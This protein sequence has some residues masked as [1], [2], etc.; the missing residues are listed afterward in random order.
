MKIK[1]LFLAA[2]AFSVMPMSAQETYENVKL[3]HQDLNGTARYVGMGG[4]MDALGADLSTISSNPAGLGLFRRSQAAISFG[5]VSQQDGKDFA[6]G[7]KTNASFDQVGFVYATKNEGKSFLNF[8]FNYHK[9][10]N[11]DF[12]LST[13]GSL[14]DASQNKLTYIKARGGYLFDNNGD[15]YVSSSRLDELYAH[16]LL[17]E[18]DNVYRYK[19]ATA[20]NM[21]RANTGYIGNYEFSMSG[22][23]N[24][25]VYLGMTF[26]V[27]DVHY[28]GYSEY[29]EQLAANAMNLSSI[30]VADNR[31]ITGD[32]YEVKFGAIFRPIEN[33]PFRIGVSIASPIFYDLTS[34]SRTS[35]N[36][37]YVDGSYDFKISTPWKFGL[38][39]GHTVGDF[40][41]LG[42]VYE[43]E[44][45]GSI[46]SRVNDGEGWDYYD[47]YYQTSSSDKDMNDQTEQVLKGVS[48]LK[49][50]LEFKPIKDFAIRVGYNYQ[51]AIYDKNGAKG[52]YSNGD[53]VQSPGMYYSSTMDY[54]NW[55]DTNRFTFGLGYQIDRFSVDLAYQYS[56]T[57]GDFHP[58]AD[59]YG[60]FK[61]TDGTTEKVDNYATVTSVSNKR[62]QLLFTLGYRF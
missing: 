59:A 37:A 47:G 8:G 1:Y 7:N 39:L 43:Y 28:K 25:R 45:Y 58:F 20:F 19:S 48:T 5:L 54:T 29:S 21:D 53:F 57:N 3:A 42:A 60:D 40:L 17:L 15:D 26:G 38:S 56:A 24:E 33:S 55:K 10:Q 31:K 30:T 12:I 34:E 46:D 49:L 52:F 14:N 22:N 6:N 11:F 41:A 32:G 16:S 35:L 23:F 9:S 18:S 2:L 13:A 44:D 51:S 36:G 62:H 27:Y 4:A 50:G 61:N